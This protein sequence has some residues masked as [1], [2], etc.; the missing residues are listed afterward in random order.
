MSDTNPTNEQPDEITRIFNDRTEIHEAIRDAGQRVIREHQLADQPLVVW[1][2]GEI[3]W[4]DPHT[5]EAV[6][7]PT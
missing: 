5:L 1:G 4:L 3:V 2:D 6:S 7:A